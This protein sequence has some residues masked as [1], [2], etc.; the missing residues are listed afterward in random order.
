[1]QQVSK[2]IELQIVESYGD[3]DLIGTA[4]SEKRFQKMKEYEAG[5]SDSICEITKVFQDTKGS[6][7]YGNQNMGYEEAQG[8]LFK[9]KQLPAENR[10]HSFFYKK[11]IE[12]SMK[13]IKRIYES[14]NRK[15]LKYRMKDMDD[16]D[17]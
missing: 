15:K 4:P 9:I 5:I 1:M 3:E 6:F 13:S 14:R 10:I 12:D 2:Q 11:A 17:F 8:L 7:P 16:T